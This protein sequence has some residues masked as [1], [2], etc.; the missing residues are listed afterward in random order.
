[1]HWQMLS[2]QNYEKLT[3]MHRGAYLKLKILT[4]CSSPF[5]YVDTKTVQTYFTCLSTWITRNILQ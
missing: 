1:M 3:I 4:H 2:G 5:R